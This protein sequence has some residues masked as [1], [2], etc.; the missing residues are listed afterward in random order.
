MSSIAGEVRSPTRTTPA[1]FGSVFLL[2]ST[3]AASGFVMRVDP[4][5][6]QESG[7]V[8]S[9][10][11]VFQGSCA[12]IGVSSPSAGDAC[13]VIRGAQGATNAYQGAGSTTQDAIAK[14]DVVPRA[15]DGLEAGS[16]LVG[17]AATATGLN[18]VGETLSITTKFTQAAAAAA[19]GNYV[20]ALH[21]VSNGT[22]SA[23]LEP[24]CEGRG[25]LC[26][27][28][29][30]KSAG[31]IAKTAMDHLPDSVYDTY[32]N[33]FQKSADSSVPLPQVDLTDAKRR[34]DQPL[35]GLQGA[36]DQNNAASSTGNAGLSDEKALVQDDTTSSGGDGKAY[37][38]AADR[39]SMVVVDESASPPPASVAVASSYTAVAPSTQEDD[40]TQSSSDDSS[41]DASQ[42]VVDAAISNIKSIMSNT[43]QGPGSSSGESSPS[44][45]ASPSSASSVRNCS[46][47]SG[48][49]AC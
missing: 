38:V 34:E 6:A 1:L 28:A 12:A 46:Y 17:S 41:N 9:D 14:A 31:A 39:R 10:R 44:A 30:D 22:L 7:Q 40:S 29:F 42:Q 19:D 33:V 4:A 13:N 21:S 2:V 24:V 11:T 48:R 49:G 5:I 43:W 37:E 36:S 32:Y 25:S 45:P 27:D 26:A 23:A 35:G 15:V 47:G 3:L 18:V 8:V 16:A 20:D